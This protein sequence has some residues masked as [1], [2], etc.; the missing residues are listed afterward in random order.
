MATTGYPLQALLYTVALHRHLQLRMP[1]YDYERH[2]GGYLYLFMR[3]LAGAD[4]PRCP[5][6]GRCLGVFAHRW[7]RETIEAV[8]DALGAASGGGV[9]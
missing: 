7:R 8:D 5:E 3:G 4:T 6:T 9:A 1:G 2:M